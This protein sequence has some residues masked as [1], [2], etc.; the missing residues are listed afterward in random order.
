MKHI[1]PRVLL[2]L[3]IVIGLMAVLVIQNMATN[4]QKQAGPISF[5][6]TL[7]SEEQ[8]LKYARENAVRNG[9]VGEPTREE[10]ALMTYGSYLVLAGENL[11]DTFLPRDN[12]VF[13]YQVFGDIPVLNM[14]G[15]GAGRTDIDALVFVYDA[16]TGMEFHGRALVADKPGAFDLS[17]IPADPGPIAGLQPEFVPTMIVL[18]ELDFKPEV[19]SEIVP[20]P[21]VP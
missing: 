12:P 16:L 11:N 21:A 2:L 7:A 9:L 8:W 6:T 14:L 4:Q 19:T 5:D 13:V 1:H 15:S 3:V 10:S 20:L 18:P 17:F